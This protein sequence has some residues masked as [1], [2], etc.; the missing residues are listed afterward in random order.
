MR[1]S[2]LKKRAEFQR[3]RG[4]GRYSTT[5][6]VM[7]GKA[8]PVLGPALGPRFGFTVTKKLGNAVVRNRI[9]RR[10][11]AALMELAPQRADQCFD[12]VVI[13]RNAAFAQSFDQLKSELGSA[14]QRV[15]SNPVGKSSP[16]RQR[17][18]KS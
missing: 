17:T 2:T 14:F 15:H 10:L 18:G 1:L 8:R 13:A 7:E 6:F 4:G 5:S 11:R 3:V 12:Y 16:A 9:R